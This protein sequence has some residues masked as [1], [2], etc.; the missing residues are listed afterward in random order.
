MNRPTL[1]TGNLVPFAIV[2][3]CIAVLAG[4]TVGG[5]GGPILSPLPV[6]H[7][8]APA[9]ITVLPGVSEEHGN[10]LISC[11]DGGETCVVVIAD[12]G[13]ASYNE[14]GG[15]PSVMPPLESQDSRNP[16]F[17]A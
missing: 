17:Y 4:C 3:L 9:E 2:A 11:P 14:T 10:V 7:G 16:A 6:G 13:S 15:M 8:V 1:A 12:D 5:G